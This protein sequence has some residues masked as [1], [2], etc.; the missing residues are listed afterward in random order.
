MMTFG[1]LVRR[2]GAH[3]PNKDAF[4]ELDRRVTWGQLDRRTDALGRGLRH[5]DVKKGDRVAVLAHDCIEVAET[6]LTCAKIGAIRV[7]LNARLAAAEIASLIKDSTPSVVAYGGEHQRVIDLIKPEIDALPE[8]P[9]L[10]GFGGSHSGAHDYEEL[11]VRHSS[12]VRLDQSPSDIAM[13]AYTSGSTGLPK[14]AIYPHD[15]FLRT[16]LYTAMNEGLV[17]DMVWLQA[18]PAAGVPM[19]HMLRNIFLAGTCVIVGP[20]NAEKALTL[21]ARERTTN[22]VLVPTMLAS[23][24]TVDN[25]AKY[26]VSS[27]KLLG[28]GAAPLP[29]ATIREAMETFGCPFLQMYGT[30]ELLGMSNM[31]FPSDHQLGLT[32]RPEVLSSIGRPLSYVDTRIVDEENRDVAVGEVGELVVRSDVAFPGYWN[33]P[34]KT[35]EMFLGDWMRTGDL[36][37]RDDDG[38]VYLSD[39]A[40]FRM[41]TGGFNVFPTEIENVLAEHPAVHEVSVFGL[42]DPTWGDRIEAVVTLKPQQSIEPETLREFCKDKIANFKIPKKIEIWTEM[43]KGATGKIL[44]RSIIE[45]M[46]ARTDGAAAPKQ[47]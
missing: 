1:D 29:P 15:K 18:M 35:A 23:L 10:I 36:A 30:T 47:S 22:C 25:V 41:K 45:M 3:W 8:P 37:R 46:I 27:M 5:L 26:D 40:K 28:Y 32:S 20:W 13:I 4:V 12:D 43:P 31:L 19:M 39:R 21:I 42:P 33:A 17:H 38:Y 11:I 7:G 44:K 24:L 16:I 14:G 6:F 9:L 34:E 2:N